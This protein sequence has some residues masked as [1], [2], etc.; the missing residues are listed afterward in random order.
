MLLN[1]KELAS[2]LKVS[3]ATIDNLMKKGMPY[4]KIGKSVRFNLEEIFK[5]LKEKK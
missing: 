1:K 5:W 2:K 4:L 3:V